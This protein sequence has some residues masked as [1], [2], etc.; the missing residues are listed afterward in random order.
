M[1][2]ISKKLS[3]V[4][5]QATVEAAIVLPIV[6]TM[7]LMLVQPAIFL[8]DLIVMNSAATE[9]VRLLATN[10]GSS[11]NVDDYVRRRLSAIP[12]VD[13]F[14]I[15]G[16]ECSYEIET[17]QADGDVCGVSI[18]NEFKPLPLLDVGLRAMN[19]LNSRGNV[20]IEVKKEM[21]M[22]PEWK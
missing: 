20:L 10:S 21:R 11:D 15:H 18:K 9:T 12:Q 19:C 5:G 17:W 6:M 4:R 3:Q 13:S 2:L 1:L 8:Y 14:H 7:I 16:S 22:Q